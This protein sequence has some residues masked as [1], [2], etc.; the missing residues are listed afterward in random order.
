MYKAL[1]DVINNSHEYTSK[2]KE[3]GDWNVQCNY[4]IQ[5]VM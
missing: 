3:M 1:I 4:V 2:E 5:K